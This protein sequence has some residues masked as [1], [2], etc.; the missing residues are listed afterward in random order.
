M[1]LAA[2]VHAQDAASRRDKKEQRK[3]Q[4][5]RVMRR[6]EEGD[7]I[8][9][10]EFNVAGRLNTDGWSAYLEYGRRVSNTTTTML[11][12][13]AG[14]RKDPKEDKTAR[15]YFDQYGYGSSGVPF[16]YGKENIFYQLKLGLGQRR[17]I[18]GKGNK[19]GVEVS[20]VYL[21]GLALAMLRPY[22]VQAEDAGGIRYVKYTEETKELFLSPVGGS[23]LKRGWDELKVVPGL[24]GKLGMRFDWAEFNKVVSALEVGVNAEVYSKK[25]N[26]MVGHPGKQF[27]FDAYVSLI[28]GKRW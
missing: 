17:M 15:T 10:H 21:G 20:A 1:L 23:G 12:F 8:Y 16:V 13:E 4:Q 22:Y 27:F 9:Q 3:L 6:E 11:Q 2:T 26:I 5:T 7:F 25:I 24:H 19:N 28:L 14:E 18:G